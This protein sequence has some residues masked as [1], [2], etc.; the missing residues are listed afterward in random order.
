MIITVTDP[1]QEP[2]IHRDMPGGFEDL[3]EY[4]MEV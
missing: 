4:V 1:L 3:Q 2:M